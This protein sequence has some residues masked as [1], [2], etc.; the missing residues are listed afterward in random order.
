MANLNVVGEPQ[1]LALAL[2]ECL[3]S[4]YP[5]IEVYAV[6]D[7]PGEDHVFARDEQSKP[8]F[9][10]LVSTSRRFAFVWYYIHPQKGLALVEDLKKIT[11][12]EERDF[13][14][15]FPNIPR[16]TGWPSIIRY[17]KKQAGQMLNE[18]IVK[19]GNP[20][21]EPQYYSDE[22]LNTYRNYEWYEVEGALDKI[23]GK[24]KEMALKRLG[25]HQD[26]WG[27]IRGYCLYAGCAY[28]LAYP[29][30]G[31]GMRD[32]DVEVLF[33]PEWFTNTRAA[34]TEHCG[35]EEFGT[36]NYFKGKTRWLDLMWNSFHTETGDFGKD[37]CIY[38]DE[39]RHKSDRWATISQRPMFD[40]TTK[41]LIYTPG[42][43][44][45]VSSSLLPSKEQS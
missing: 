19:K 10:M 17:G 41:E 32:I 20:Q 43:L 45:K 11:L 4:H 14:V 30:L 23:L 37:V 13:V 8:M 16:K 42:W 40:L 39:M 12:M 29:Q 26:K 7:I 22:D 2:G 44:R 36:P 35:I 18:F 27:N 28:S 24:A 1:T 38:M 21:L 9:D 3:L 34:Y 15:K 33:S 31:F 25:K 5:G 6:E